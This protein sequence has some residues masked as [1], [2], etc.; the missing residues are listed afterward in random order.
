MTSSFLIPSRCVLLI[1][2]EALAV[3]DVT[4][5]RT[6]L[7]QS[8]PWQDG[9]LEDIVAGLIRKDCNGK[10]VLVLNDMTD[11]H[12]K[13]GQ[14]LPKVGPFDK[15]SVLQRRLQVA[16]PSYPI[17]GGLQI[18]DGG[19][20]KTAASGV[21]LFAAVPM[22]DAVARTID[23]VRKSMAPVA[24]FCLLP[25]ESADMAKKLADVLGK[26]HRRKAQWSVLIGQHRSG[27]LR[28]VIVRN[29]QLAMTRMTPIVSKDAEYKT[30]A[31][32]VL[33]EFKA[34][35]SYLSR[36]GYSAEDGTEL[37]VLAGKEYGEALYE[38]LDV[39]CEFSCMT[40][41]EAARMLGFSLGVQEDMRSADALHAAW[42]G[43]KTRF[44][45]PLD[46]PDLERIHRPRQVATMAIVLLLLSVS[47]GG[48]HLLDQTQKLFSAKDDLQMQKSVK[49]RLDQELQA[50]LDRMAKL[51]YDVRLIGGSIAAFQY[52][53]NREM[54]PVRLVEK[55]GEALGP[56]LRLDM[57]EVSYVSNELPEKDKVSYY[58][59]S[60]QEEE[61]PEVD[62]FL[63]L[64]FPPTIE[65]EEGFSEVRALKRRLESVMP[66]Y[67]IIIEKQIAERVYVEGVS[68]EASTVVEKG[69]RTEDYTAKIRLKGPV[70]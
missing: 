48:W 30:W 62:A 32:E 34:T 40:T 50:E 8:I 31:Q 41:S 21:Y 66:E 52:Y 63:Y 25:T 2:D 14:R 39:P 57:I 45:L 37:I 16:F 59:A 26:Q 27:G 17:R 61:K 6:R 47:G 54:K 42:A 23:A 12:F 33:Q 10:P 4:P 38:R 13:G 9:D 18:K 11:Q 64:S 58:G 1:G 3:Y 43:R 15:A 56:E 51:G 20:K 28:Q 60:R 55:I 7:V 67:T 19:G 35:I 49:E 22:S 69:E 46:A 53:E 5:R 36:F 29:G 68:G 44:L 65:P 70:S 24:G